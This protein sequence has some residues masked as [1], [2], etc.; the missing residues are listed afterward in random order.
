MP[1]DYWFGNYGWNDGPMSNKSVGQ[2]SSRKYSFQL[3]NIRSAA[4]HDYV[5]PL[6]AT[7]VRVLV[8]SGAHHSSASILHL[9]RGFCQRGPIRLTLLDRA[10]LLAVALET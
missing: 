4:R 7:S 8:D 3:I 6:P 10:T 1:D 2:L 5:Y 9:L